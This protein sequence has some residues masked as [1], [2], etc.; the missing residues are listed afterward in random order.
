MET[1]DALCSGLNHSPA[2][3]TETE[4]A[5]CFGL[6]QYLALPINTFFSRKQD[7][8]K[9]PYLSLFSHATQAK[10]ETGWHSIIP[11]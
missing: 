11:S 10:Q 6:N 3:V 9:L 8:R 2:L 5:F 4:D 7:F 1:E